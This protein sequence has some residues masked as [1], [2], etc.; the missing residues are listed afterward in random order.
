M[1]EGFS[2]IK[3][4]LKA[5]EAGIQAVPDRELE[6]SILAGFASTTKDDYIGWIKHAGHM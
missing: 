3:G 2:I 6:D 4:Y 1:E 5:N